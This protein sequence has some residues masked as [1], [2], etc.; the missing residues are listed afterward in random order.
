MG[1]SETLIGVL[2]GGGITLAVEFSVKLYEKNQLKKH[3]ASLL[4]YDLKSIEEYLN[5]ENQNVDIRYSTEWQSM[6]ANCTFL[7]N[8][9]VEYI[10]KIYDQVYNQNWLMNNSNNIK[11]TSAYAELQK[12]IATDENQKYKRILH[13]LQKIKRVQ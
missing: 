13:T 5:I 10:Y 11:T 3:S 2:I 4:Y 12:L 6:V 8:T 7:K 1:M 9:E